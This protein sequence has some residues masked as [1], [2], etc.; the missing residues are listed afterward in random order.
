MRRGE[1]ERMRVEKEER[2]KVENEQKQHHISEHQQIEESKLEEKAKEEKLR[3]ERERHRL[4]TIKKEEQLK[5]KLRIEKERFESE[6]AERERAEKE[7]LELDRLEKERQEQARLKKEA[8]EQERLD[9]EKQERDRLEKERAEKAEKDRLEEEIAERKRE[10]ERR[11]QERLDKEKQEQEQ[12]RLDK[13]R[14]DKE[15]AEKAEKER[16]EKERAEREREE[17]NRAEQLKREQQDLLTQ[18]KQKQQLEEEER[19]RLEIKR[20]EDQKAEN[21]KQEQLRVEQERK[22]EL[23]RQRL[24]NEKQEHLRL[25]KARQERDLLLKQ[26]EDRERIEREEAEKKRAEFLQQE[27]LLKQQKQQLDQQREE[28]EKAQRH[29]AQRQAEQQRIAQQQHFEK[30]RSQSQSEQEESN[31]WASQMKKPLAKL[32]A[33]GANSTSAANAFG[34]SPDVFGVAAGGVALAS[35]SHPDLSEYSEYSVVSDTNGYTPTNAYSAKEAEFELQKQREAEMP[36]Q[37]LSS[38]QDDDSSEE[39]ETPEQAEKRRREKERERRRR[40][41]A[42]LHAIIE[43]REKIGSGSG[44]QTQ[45]FKAFHKETQVILAVKEFNENQQERIEE[46]EFASLL[47]LRH[48]NLIGYYGTIYNEQSLWVIMDHCP[49]GS[50]MDYARQ[51]ARSSG[52][53]G[54][55]EKHICYTVDLILKAVSYLHSQGIAH[56]NIRGSN[57][58]LTGGFGIKLSDYG[59][60]GDDF[61]SVFWK[62]PE[63]VDPFQQPNQV[64]DEEEKRD[65]DFARYSVA[66]IWAIGITSLELANGEPPYFDAD[67]SRKQEITDSI[68]NSPAPH[69][70][71][72]QGVNMG[73]FSDSLCDLVR[74]MLEKNINRRPSASEMLTHPVIARLNSS[75]NPYQ[76]KAE[77]T[78]DDDTTETENDSGSG[79]GSDSGSGSGSESEEEENLGS[80]SQNR[81]QGYQQQP[82][83]MKQD[84]NANNGVELRHGN[85]SRMDG[86]GSDGTT[87]HGKGS[88]NAMNAPPTGFCSGCIIS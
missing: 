60:P 39:K 12:E 62:G 34:A 5:E 73:R 2:I 44:G 35:A 19:I 56:R 32:S 37:S 84:E 30:Q 87:H 27:E 55:S 46:K 17:K 7:Q 21:E 65:I 81:R 71:L 28:A 58:L 82:V 49:G 24:E 76:A 9:T 10:Q 79:S 47:Q 86:F 13:E 41:S 52:S 26:Q 16:V 29:E 85:V 78:E 42:G 75:Y 40:M 69:A 8:E 63:L 31:P 61:Y 25:E 23:E 1:E 45:V 67:V 59:A 38:Q 88:F 66:D 14:L 68:I 48:P 43:I 15:S 77:E 83:R 64:E 50:V 20:L 33:Q 53:V 3:E 36:P 70:L 18:L 80:R 51:D 22:E 54:L 4:E 74:R 57:V 11:E 72:K 6:K